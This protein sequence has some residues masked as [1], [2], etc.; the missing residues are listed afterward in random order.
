MNAKGNGYIAAGRQ[1]ESW[2]DN[3]CASRYMAPE[4]NTQKIQCSQLEREELCG[5]N[6]PK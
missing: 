5:F 3:V 2:T 1:H 4:T 6:S